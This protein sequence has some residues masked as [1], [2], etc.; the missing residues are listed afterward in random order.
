MERIQDVLSLSA[1]VCVPRCGLGRRLRRDSVERAISVPAPGGKGNQW[2]SPLE[3]YKCMR[4][5]GFLIM[6][7]ALSCS[8]EA[9]RTSSLDLRAAVAPL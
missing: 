3:R 4:C 8:R 2:G 7:I 9:R 6:L 1:F 5:A